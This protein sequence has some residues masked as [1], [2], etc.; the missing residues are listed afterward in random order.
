M[1]YREAQLKK[2]KE[3]HLCIVRSLEKI[4]HQLKFTSKNIGSSLMY[5]E[6]FRKKYGR[7]RN[8]VAKKKGISVMYSEKIHQLSN[9]RSGSRK[10]SSPVF[11][12]K[13]RKSR[14]IIDGYK[15]QRS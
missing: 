3:V 6:R 12:K 4:V 8:F 10:E 7:S 13:F 2:K 9:V 5:R 1:V 11:Y 14:P 15:Q